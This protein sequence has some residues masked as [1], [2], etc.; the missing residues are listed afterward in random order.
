M[1]PD[2]S[3]GVLPVWETGAGI[4]L[5]D[6]GG[7]FM[8]RGFVLLVC[9]GLALGLARPVLAQQVGDPVS[10]FAMVGGNR[11]VLITT[12][13]DTGAIPAYWVKPYGGM[14]ILASASPGGPLLATLPIPWPTPDPGPES[15]W[16]PGTIV[17][18]APPGTYWVLMVYGLTNTTSASPSAW[19]RVVVGG[20]TA[21]TAPPLPPVVIPGSPVVS[22]ASV[23]L[24]FSG[25]FQGCPIDYLELEVGTT[26]GAK[27]VGV[28]Q[29]PGLNTFFPAVP[30]GAY[31]TR[32]RAVN[33]YGKSNRSTEIPIQTPGPCAA[34]SLPPTPVNPAVTINGSQVTLAWTLSPPTGATF[35]QITLLDPATGAPLDRLIVSSATS[36]SATVPAGNYRVRVSSGNPCGV[37]DMVPLSYLDFTVP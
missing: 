2:Y 21:C 8:T 22:G 9:L 5:V 7:R 23:A 24:G 33:A 31:Y 12:P 14:T 34:N 4:P 1:S 19:Q 17:P 18:G 3:K 6:A 10:T 15:G 27:D 11:A 30:P 25:A 35:H 20:T 29:L 26:P 16:C 28:Y 32:A 36:V 37:R 13:C